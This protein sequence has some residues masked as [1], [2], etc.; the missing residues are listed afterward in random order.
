MLN[1]DTNIRTTDRI[2]LCVEDDL[3]L[4]SDIVEELE[5]VGYR[6][7]KAENG[8]EALRNLGICKPD[9]ILCDITMPVMGGYDLLRSIRNQ[10]PDLD[11]VPFVFMS[12][13]S[14]KRDVIQGRTLGADDYLLKPLDYDVMLA[15]I[16]SRLS[17][18]ERV[19]RNMVVQLERERRELLDTTMLE[20]RDAFAG[21]ANAFDSLSSGVIFLDS[22][23]QVQHMNRTAQQITQGEDGLV[24]SAQSLRTT[25]TASTRSLKQA[26]HDALGEPNN[27]S[28][29]TIPRAMHRPLVL[30]IYP[31]S[32]GDAAGSPAVAVFVVDPEM[33][34]RLS[35]EMASR[36]Y[37][38]TRAE[39]RLA[40]ALADGK[41]LDEIATEFGVSPTT[42]SFH[43]QN[44]FR[45]T[46]TSR[47]ADLV[48]L[49]MRGALAF[50]P[51]EASL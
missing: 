30:Q 33:R 5:A 28:M 17:Q 6:V 51:D 3:R 46:H 4:R 39:A 37:D 43:L 10:R 23:G 20:T 50:Q 44:L 14:D 12:V 34:P 47:Q 19:R 26:I 45:K 41:R 9:L 24:L 11:D 48:A 25:S 21:L 22:I 2:I 16:R 35:Q 7:E 32:S 1:N 49:L 15:T 36:M 18:V 38:L 40:V 31:L 29:V 27:S 13:L 8:E 42:V